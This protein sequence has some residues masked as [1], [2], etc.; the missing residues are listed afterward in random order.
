[1]L[2]NVDLEL[3][4]NHTFSEANSILEPLT[5]AAISEAEKL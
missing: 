2:G 5:L 1:M 3:G 4:S